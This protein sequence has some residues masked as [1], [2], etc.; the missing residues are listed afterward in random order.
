MK[1]DGYLCFLD[2]AKVFDDIRH[3]DVFEMLSHHALF[4]DVIRIIQKL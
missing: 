4:E 1:Q 2:Y 3:K